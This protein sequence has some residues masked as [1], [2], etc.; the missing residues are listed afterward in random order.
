MSTTPPRRSFELSTFLGNTCRF[1][2]FTSKLAKLG[3]AVRFWRPGGRWRRCE[4]SSPPGATFYLMVKT[5]SI[6]T[7]SLFVSAL[8]AMDGI[9]QAAIVKLSGSL[10]TSANSDKSVDFDLVVEYQAVGGGFRQ[11]LH[12][13]SVSGGFSE[14]SY[15]PNRRLLTLRGGQSDLQEADVVIDSDLTEML[16]R[17]DQGMAMLPVS[18]TGVGLGDAGWSELR[19]AVCIGPRLHA[20]EPSSVGLLVAAIAACAWYAFR[21][22]RRMPQ[23]TLTA[24]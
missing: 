9:S 17:S 3:V 12:G 21:A 8:I 24:A 6:A 18:L 15:D 10:T 1:V 22:R 4:S 2:V 7:I 5:S 19:G 16:L 23:A 13:L 14:V 11:K 20:P